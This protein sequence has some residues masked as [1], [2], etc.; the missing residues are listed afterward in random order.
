MAQINADVEAYQGGF[1]TS[2]EDANAL[3]LLTLFLRHFPALQHLADPAIRLADEV[4]VRILEVHGREG[5]W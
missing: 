5:E 1:A 4:N 3:K 2:A